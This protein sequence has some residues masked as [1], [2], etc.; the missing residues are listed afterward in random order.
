[1]AEPGTIS[2]S[3]TALAQALK[4]LLLA[5]V[6]SVLVEWIGMVFWWEDQ[7]LQHSRDMLLS[8]LGFLETDFRRSV[9]AAEPVA[10]A[11]RLVD[12]LF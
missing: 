12:Q 3:L 11:R 10:F 6:F 7:G 5:L 4:W 2:R 1:M 9:V 8:E